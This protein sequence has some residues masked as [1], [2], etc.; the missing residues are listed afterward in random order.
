MF[1]TK[2]IGNLANKI[3]EELEK[4]IRDRRGLKSEWNKI[5]HQVMMELENSWKWIIINE[6]VDAQNKQK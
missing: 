1:N 4:D 2:E 6:I 5:D 3:I